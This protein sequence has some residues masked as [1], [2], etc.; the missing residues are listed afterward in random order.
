VLATF[1]I[2]L[3][4][5]VFALII[6]FDSKGAFST[7][8]YGVEAFMKVFIMMT[9]LDYGGSFDDGDSSAFAFFGR[10]VFLIFD[11]VVVI[12]LTNL[13]VGLAVSDVSQLE[14][15]G[16]AQQLAKQ[17][18]SL[19]PLEVCLYS[20]C[21]VKVLPP[22]LRAALK[23][24]RCSSTWIISGRNNLPT[25]IFPQLPESVRKSILHIALRNQVGTSGRQSEDCVTD[26]PL[27]Q[28]NESVVLKCRK[29]S[30]SS[31]SS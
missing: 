30:S 5:F 20:K 16:R 29:D 8:W 14:A 23:E 28:A 17:I 7:N 12:V 19:K 31:S 6:L 2:L 9:E 10:I 4:G 15:Q 3:L 11:S 18:A 24:R 22:R 25:S 26:G 13:M 27:L 1:V 21:L